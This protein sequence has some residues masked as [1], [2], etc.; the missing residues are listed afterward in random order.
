MKRNKT[1][2]LFVDYDAPAGHVGFN[3]IWLRSLCREEKAAVTTVMPADFF[4][5]ILS[6][7]DFPAVKNIS[8]PGCLCKPSL[9]GVLWRFFSI[10]RLLWIRRHI[11]LDAYDCVLISSFDTLSFFLGA[12][13]MRKRCC[14]VCHNNIKQV[15][16]HRIANFCFRMLSRKHRIIVLEDYIKSFL[17]QRN[18]A[19]NVSVIH[20]GCPQPFGEDS[21]CAVPPWFD[22]LR[23]KYRKI[24][25]SPSARS[26]GSFW[27]DFLKDPEF[28][29]LLECGDF[30]FV[31]RTSADHPVRRGFYPVKT[32]LSDAEYAAI[33]S[34][35][36]AILIAYPPSFAYRTSAV[37]YEAL[38]NRKN[39]LIYS[40]PA[41]D[42][43]RA[44]VGDDVFFDEASG[45]CALIDGMD[46]PG[47]GMTPV[48][49]EEVKTPRIYTEIKKEFE[50]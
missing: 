4:N 31:A 13:F 19:H 25:F 11:R 15:A 37:L 29:R 26:T 43:Y 32:R 3:R 27:H 33:F 36:D 10:L 28:I 20:H 8:L 6:C 39:V 5:R 7:S 49:P 22:D 1:E 2:I 30:V 45:L 34:A 14:L 35:S 12:S 21:S 42:P 16:E 47:H 46:E 38:A 23:K 24:I 44:I 9:K 48:I 40:N 41:M 50:Q 18:I 17:E